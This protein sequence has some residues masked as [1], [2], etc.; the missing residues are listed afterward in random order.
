MNN[1]RDSIIEFLNA[2]WG[3]RWYAIAA[4]WFICLVG[5]SV[6]AVMP[7]QYQVSARVFVD[8]S[9]LLRPLLRGIAVEPNVED[10]V[11]LMRQTLLSRGN[12]EKVMRMTDL[13]L[14][15]TTE[16]S[17]DK[18]ISSLQR[19]TTISSE[20]SAPNLFSIGLTYSEPVRAR[21]IV[22]AF[23]TVFVENNIGENRD[24]ADAAREF[25]DEQ[26]Q[27]YRE[28]LEQSEKQLANFQQEFGKLLP[29]AAG[30]ISGNYRSTRNAL[31]EAIA[32]RD[33]LKQQLSTISRYNEVTE[34]GGFGAG[35]PSADEVRISQ[36]E[37]TVDNLLS[38][39]TENHPDVVVANRRLKA[40]REKMEVTR[41]NFE[42]S[43]VDEAPSATIRESNPVYEALQ[44]ELVTQEANIGVLSQ[45]FKEAET[46]WL[47][48]RE[49][50]D[51]A[52]VLAAEQQKL[53]RDYGIIQ[54]K[55]QQLLERREAMKIATD[56]SI[57]SDDVKFRIIDPPVVPTS[58]VG[59]NRPFFLNVV[60][61]FGFGAGIVGAALLVITRETFQDVRSLRS[62]FSIPVYGAVRDLKTG[63]RRGKVY[64]DMLG[65]SLA[66]GGLVAVLLLL[67]LLE[68]QVGL[69]NI[70]SIENAPQSLDQMKQIFDSGV[71]ILEGRV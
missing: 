39:Y 50:A 3:R 54:K 59:P 62:A 49:R 53:Q 7:D 23:T 16:E 24:D 65:V 41:A 61:L 32:Q 40:L 2:F 52:P 71:A 14:N 8:T 35:P 46:Q 25:L 56:R 38:Q 18:I 1:G 30:N 51:M 70:V 58:P 21:D 36:L 6:V 60:L 33:A 42:S 63:F 12:I 9:S 69:P 44:I 67:L 68:N 57:K 29:E 28:Q 15:V 34:G 48:V 43:P 20:R 47:K 31:N 17:K 26:T 10:E 64:L 37:A 66:G 5:W 13:D 11:R 19:K 45:R 22:Q 55:Y 4:A 27:F